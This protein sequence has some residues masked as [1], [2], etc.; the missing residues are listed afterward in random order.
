MA[1]Y[2]FE[3]NLASRRS[4]VL[5]E[6]TLGPEVATAVRDERFKLVVINEQERFYDLTND[7]NELAPLPLQRLSSEAR[8][9]YEGLTQILSQTTQ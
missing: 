1:P 5:A 9:A 6:G 8:E 2:L 3:A 7:P 4:W